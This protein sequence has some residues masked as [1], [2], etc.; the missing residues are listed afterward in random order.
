MDNSH[1][2]KKS[3]KT[4]KW[5]SAGKVIDGDAVIVNPHALKAWARQHEGYDFIVTYKV[6]GRATDKERMFAYLFGPLMQVAE[7][8][9]LEAGHDITPHD[10]YYF[11][12][13]RFAT[14]VWRDPFTGK[15]KERIIDISDVS[16]PVDVLHT[17]L[18][19]VIQFLEENFQAEIP[20][21]S[22][23]KVDLRFGKGFKSA[24]NYVNTTPGANH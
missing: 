17:F 23:Y 21:S 14:E 11:F 3:R 13:S 10:I 18:Q 12:K 4:I 8:C 16:T 19:R 24:K 1:G 6:A 7:Q 9:F 2:I 22:Q 5:S 15:V 20:D